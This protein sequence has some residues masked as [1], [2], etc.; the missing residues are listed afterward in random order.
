MKLKHKILIITLVSVAIVYSVTLVLNLISSRDLAR[1]K[2]T[3]IAEAISA[4]NAAIVAQKLNSALDIAQTYSTSLEVLMRSNNRDRALVSKLAESILQNNETLYGVWA[5]FEPDAFD[6][7][8]SEFAGTFGHDAT[9]RVIPYWYRDENRIAFEVVYG[10]DDPE[11]GAFYTEPLRRQKPYITEPTTY[12]IGGR[13]V[14]LTSITAPVRYNGQVVGVVGVDFIL[15]TLQAMVNEI[16][17]FDEG[18]ARILSHEG[19]VVAHPVSDRIGDIAG[20][21]QSD[22]REVAALYA[23][24]IREGLPLTDVSYSI[25]LGENV[26]KTISPI[27]IGNTGTPVV[28]WYRYPGKGHLWGR[29]QANQGHGGGGAHWSSY[30]WCGIVSCV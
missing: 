21:L 1:E 16:T 18:F 15:D 20:E 22:D 12:I 13:E 4:E 19:I 2:A 7:R 25:A 28:L 8:D 14:M 11:L 10:Y 9:G 26:F 6:G 23:K 17:I 29:E 5:V 27:V 30:N 24:S 3:T